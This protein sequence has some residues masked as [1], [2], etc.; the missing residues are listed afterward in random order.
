MVTTNAPSEKR[1]PEPLTE[2]SPPRRGE[3]DAFE[4]CISSVER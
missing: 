3:A 2:S 1:F 4:H